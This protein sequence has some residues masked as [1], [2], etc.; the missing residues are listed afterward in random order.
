MC[1]TLYIGTS[2]Q[3]TGTLVHVWSHTFVTQL[4]GALCGFLLLYNFLTWFDAEFLG[5]LYCFGLPVGLLFLLCLFVGISVLWCLIKLIWVACR[6]Q[7]LVWCAAQLPLNS[8]TSSLTGKL[9]WLETCPGQ[10]FL[11]QWFLSQN[12]HHIGRTK[13]HHDI[14]FLQ[15]QVDISQGLPVLIQHFTIHQY[16]SFLDGN[17][18]IDQIGHAPHWIAVYRNLQ[19]SPILC[20]NSCHLWIAP[21]I[22][23]DPFQSCQNMWLSSY[24]VDIWSGQWVHI[25]KSSRIWVFISGIYDIMHH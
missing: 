6:S 23:I 9:Y 14:K 7:L 10:C 11:P 5:A 12:L 24:T 22:H 18:S 21:R 3:G 20:A 16:S 8:Q 17:W 4:S 2:L 25:P 15:F 13:I 1:W 19:I